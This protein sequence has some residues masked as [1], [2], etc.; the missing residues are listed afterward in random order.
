MWKKEE[1][2]A[3]TSS[4]P[5]TPQSDRTLA[6]AAP[7]P[8]A[9]VERATIG[10]SITVHGEVTGDEDL[11]IR[12]RVEGSVDLHDHAITV[13]PGGEVIAR[14]HGRIV[15]IDGRVEGDI[16]GSDQVALRSSAWVEG[17]I[18][19]PRVVLEDGSRFRGL[20]DMGDADEGA[21]RSGSAADRDPKRGEDTDRDRA[22]SNRTSP[23]VDDA[24]RLA[25]QPKA[26]SDAASEAGSEGP[27][28]GS[29]ATP[30]EL[31]L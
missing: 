31:P 20:V 21:N 27:K 12:G 2:P 17:D 15:T 26:K 13:A 19:A 3:E 1:I 29:A 16:D 28:E 8:R 25:T 22:D 7:T 4:Q 23:G 6:R 11:V 30:V 18:T 10:R 9:P 5:S 14:I 24:E